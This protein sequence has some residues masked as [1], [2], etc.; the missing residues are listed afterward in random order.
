M[1]ILDEK[2]IIVGGGIIGTATAYYLAKKKA[3]V[4]LLEGSD[5]AAGTSSACDQAV[6]L[7]TKKPGP[8]LELAMESA[9]LYENLEA[10]LNMDIEYK[11]G[12]GMILFETEEHREMMTALVREQQAVGLDVSVISAEEVHERQKGL[13]DHI[14]GSTWS[15]HDAKVNSYKTTFAF[16]EAAMDLGARILTGEQVTEL[17]IKDNR[18]IGVKTNKGSY[19]ADKVVLATGA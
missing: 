9:R 11:K 2:V 12:G 3:D 8:L 15:E 4:L 1:Y 7:Q 13:R 5:I 18:I 19:Y 16:A 14:I 17:L 6:L 10:E